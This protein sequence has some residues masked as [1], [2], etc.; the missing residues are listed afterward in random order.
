MVAKSFT[1]SEQYYEGARK[2][3]TA[4][5]E[6][7]T[8]GLSSI[9]GRTR[10]LSLNQTTSAAQG[11]EKPKD[12]PPSAHPDRPESLP[13]DI[14]KEA[15]GML[16]RF[17]VEAAKRL[18]EVQKAEDAADEALLKFGTNIRNFLRDAVTITGP[19]DGEGKEGSEVLFESKDAEG[20][21]VI[22]TTRFDAQLHVIHTTLDS[23]LKD[24]QSPEWQAWADKFDAQAITDS[25]SKDLEKY[26]ELRKAME[27]LVPEKVEYS[28]FWKRYYFLRH[29]IEVDE[30]KRK[31]TLKKGERGK[32]FF[33]PSVTYCCSLL[34]KPKLT[35]NS[36][37]CRS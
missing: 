7:A 13:A 33:Y 34:P 23:F 2:E 6:Q 8:K 36:I 17:K 22:H 9:V 26:E 35:I 20:K 21:R 11:E 10:G 28:Q 37:C 3:Y 12:D 24:P 16:S 18:K 15:E 25:V 32:N 29:V 1:Q 30:Q 5:S 19:E 27:K 14:V 31:D 4:A